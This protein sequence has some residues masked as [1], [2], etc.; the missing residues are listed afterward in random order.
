MSILEAPT[1][2]GSWKADVAHSSIEFSIRH[3]VVSRFRGSLSDFDASLAFGADGSVSLSGRGAV[4][5]IATRD[6]V[7]T[8]HLL[9][10]EF[11]DAEQH[12]EMTLASTSFALE[13]GEVSVSAD[14]TIRGMTHPVVLRGFLLGPV[15]DPFGGQR[16]GL[17]LATTIDSRDFGLSWNVS[18]PAG[19]F[20]LGHEVK[21]SALLEF[22][23]SPQ[24]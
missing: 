11:F 8:E 1:L 17:D 13:P 23:K 14:L 20:V 22:G 10:P 19:G 4:S 2:T 3:M 18:M 12:P 24:A 15:E 5:S 21:L 6:E 9:S 16:V 7:L